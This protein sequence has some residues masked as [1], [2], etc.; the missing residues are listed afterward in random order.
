VSGAVR[1]FCG[2]VA[3]SASVENWLV[4]IGVPEGASV[5]LV[6]LTWFIG[7]L[8]A[9]WVVNWV[10]KRVLLVWLHRIADRSKTQWDNILV[11]RGVFTRLSHI[12]PAVVIYLSAGLVFEG[13]PR[14]IGFVQ[15]AAGFY[16]VAVGLWVVDGLLNAAVC[17]YNTFKCSRKMPIKGFVQV[18]KIV[19]YIAAAVVVLS[20]LMKKDPSKLLAGMGAMTAV[21]L[22]IFKDSILGLVAGI[23]LI[24]N[25]MVHI[26]DW[27]EMPKYGADGD[28]I[29]IS[30]TTV[31]VSNWDKTIA[32][33]PTYALV[34]DSFK[35]WRG[36][37]D[38]GG[39]RIKR[40]VHIDMT[41]IRFCDEAMLRRFGRFQY[42]REY[43]DGKLK[44]LAEWNSK[45]QVDASEIV[46]GRRLTN[47]GTF[48]AYV[49]AYLRHHPKVHQNMTFLVRH[50]APTSKGLP[51]EIYVFSNDQVWANYEGIQADIFDHILAVIPEFGLRVFQEP[52]G[53][54]LK[55]LAAN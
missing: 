43:I 21:L 32:T 14:A 39:R 6:R 27:I 35:N 31:K 12:A 13:F 45:Q 55:A 40:A 24:S 2:V 1:V 37:S 42:L 50:L 11:E 33:I 41:S 17:I 52:T 54:D 8:A 51:I 25:E 5:F 18:V 23:Q 47:V 9:A 3:V 44:E 15:T 34:S 53:A 30:L 22:L 4:G 10:V 48:R 36:M 38:S 28:V 46:N 7:V 29:D 19:L 49:A 16:M 26:G 20:I